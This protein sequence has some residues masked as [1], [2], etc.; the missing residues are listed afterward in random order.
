MIIRIYERVGTVN[1]QRRVMRVVRVY[2]RNIPEGISESAFTQKGG[3]LAGSGTS[4]YGELPP[5]SPGQYLTPDPAAPYGLKYETPSVAIADPTNFLLNGGFDFAQRTTPGT[6]TTVSDNAYGA[7]RWKQTRENA[8]LQ[9]QRNDATSETGLTSRYYGKY[10]KITNAGKFMVFQILEGQHTVPLRGKTVIFQVKMKASTAKTIRM[11][12]LE[13]QS[14]GTMDTIP[15]TFVSAWNVDSTN[16]TLGANLAVITGAESKSVTTSWQNF[17]VSVTVPSTS[18]NL[19]CA[20]WADADFSSADELNLAEAGLFLG[21]TQLIW[22]PRNIAQELL[23]CQRYYWKSFDIDIAP[24]QNAG[25][26]GCLRWLAIRAGAVGNNSP[27][28]VLPTR[29]RTNPTP[30]TYN[31]SA[32]NAQV[33]DG[34]AGADGSSTAAVLQVG[35]KLYINCSSNAA[36]A[37]GNALLVHASADAEL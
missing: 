12:I 30:T 18:K 1:V 26:D 15:G 28:F 17:T 5:G 22:T 11:A 2:D 10:K 9:Y 34:A 21:A 20:V 24:A 14:G 23:L 8:D 36:T 7:D 3:I 13:L 35:D 6:L 37:I 32:A 19:I 29:M 4:A 25:F 33:R 27:S 31:T 16:P